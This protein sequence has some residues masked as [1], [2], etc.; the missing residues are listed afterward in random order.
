MRTPRRPACSGDACSTWNSVNIRT[1]GAPSCPSAASTATIRRA[2]TY[3]RPR[4]RRSVPTAS[5]PSIT[6]FASAVRI[7]LSRAPTRRGTR[8]SGRS[9]PTVRPWPTRR[10]AVTTRG[11][12]SPPS[13]RSASIES[14][15]AS[16]RACGPAST[17]RRRP[18][19]S[20]R[21]S[22]GRSRSAI[23]TI[24]RATCRGSLRKTSTSGCTKSSAPAPASITCG[25]RPS[26]PTRTPK[27]AHADG[28][29]A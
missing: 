19:A 22:P 25:T 1:C 2:W 9:S 7:A 16:R 3:V 11:S 12:R 29:K 4:R 6:T 27:R 8:P 20:T 10:S 15:R 5:S 23:S 28:A 21:A 26:A 17:R 13:A 24:R 14:M 18:P